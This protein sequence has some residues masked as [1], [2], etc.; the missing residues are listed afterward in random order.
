MKNVDKL[1]DSTPLRYRAEELLSQ[2]SEEE[3]IQWLQSPCTRALLLTLQGDYLD[4]HQAWEAGEFT[5]ES[6]DGTAQSNTKA[7]GQM[8]AV[9]LIA[10]YIED[11]AKNDD[12]DGF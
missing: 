7:L 8:D 1:F 2:L 12:S 9:R 6:V 10:E 4:I 11:I 3:K 5:S